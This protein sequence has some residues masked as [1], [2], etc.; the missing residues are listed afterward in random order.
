MKFSTVI[1]I[2]LGLV[3]ALVVTAVA[4]LFTMDFSAY[5][6]EIQTAVKDA[7]GRDLVIEGEFA[8][9]IGLTPAVAVDKVRFANASWGSRK[10]MAT[11]ESFRAEIELLPI[12]FGEV[13]IKQIVLSGADILLETKKDGTGNWEMKGADKKDGEKDSG[14]GTI[15]T[16]DKVLVENAQLV[17]RDGV[18]NTTTKLRVDSL[19]ASA[20]DSSGPLLLNFKGSFNDQ[21][22]TLK[23]AIDSLAK[24]AAGDALNLDLGAEAGGAKV[25]L[26]GGIAKPKENKGINIAFSAEGQTLAS[27]SA[28]SGSPVPDM[29]PYK[30]G[31]TVS[32]KGDGWQIKGL[33]LRM[34]ESDLSG[35]VT[36]N[37]SAKPMSVAATLTSELLR[38]QDF[39]DKNAKPAA[40]EEKKPAAKNDGRV[41]PDDPLPL[42]GL[43]AANANVSFRGK[44]LEGPALI[45]TDLSADVTL[46]NGNLVLRPFKATYAGGKISTDLSLV[47]SSA[48]PQLAM[49]LSIADLDLAEIIKQAG[50]PGLLEGK[51]N[52]GADVNGKGKSVR[53]IMAGLNG[54]FE[55]RMGQGRVHNDLLDFLSA[56]VLKAITSWSKGD[57]G[58]RIG[59]ITIDHGIKNG[60][61]KSNATVIDTN[62][63]A[64][65]GSGGVN[66][67]KEEID[68]GIIPYAETA[69]VMA[70][71]V[72]LKVG[73]TLASPSVLPDPVAMVAGTVKRLGSTV[74][75]AATLVG[76]LLGANGGSGQK[77]AA[78]KS[79][80]PC[81]VKVMNERQSATPSKSSAPAKTGGG[82]TKPSSPIPDPGKAIEKGLKGLFGR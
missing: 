32:E 15:P 66:L 74:G 73:G 18:K 37:P 22:I 21:P 20:P 29:G 33:S 30:V 79:S 45:L 60:Q 5:K 42:D 56:D 4:I 17:Y 80:D 1:K 13:K 23:G 16:I 3:V 40:N 52:I 53:A 49:K 76:G 82:E 51:L 39:Q 69:S 47:S 63:L 9:K 72:P 70:L 62:R 64:I 8:P 54:K 34:G 6:G 78:T 12:F 50:N 58:M 19:Q 38:L 57:D 59:C 67:A 24:M 36:I 35:N 28:L 75:G 11:I 10:E 26:K 41:F 55:T 81:V 2:V 31:G 46:K 77:Q 27:L 44:K 7:T 71:L 14:G 48:I 61:L 65:V 43:K 25:T 68:F